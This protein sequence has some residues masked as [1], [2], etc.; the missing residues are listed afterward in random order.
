MRTI[1]KR[2]RTICIKQN[3]ENN[4]THNKKQENYQTDNKT[5]KEDTNKTT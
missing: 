2:K 4:K 1:T 3:T 5:K